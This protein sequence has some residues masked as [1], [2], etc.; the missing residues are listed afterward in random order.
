MPLP[1]RILEKAMRPLFAAT[2]FAVF[3]LGTSSVADPQKE[4]THVEPIVTASL[5]VHDDIPWL[6][7][8]VNGS[9]PLWFILDSGAG[10]CVVDLKQSQAL[11]LPTEGHAKGTGAG[12]GTYDVTFARDLVFCVGRLKTSVDRTQVIDLS[13]VSGPEG[14][15]LAGLLGYDF[16]ERRITVI[17]YAQE[18]LT[19]HDPKT[20]NV[21][22][23]GD[24]M[25]MVLKRRVPFV[26]GK[27]TVAGGAA[28]ERDWLVD[29]GSGDVFNDEALAGARQK[30]EVS[31][32]RGLGKEFQV[33]VATADSLELGHFSF[34][35]P[36]GSTGGM[37]IGGGLL[38]NFTVTFDYPSRRL[39]LQP[40]QNYRDGG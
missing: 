24:S 8:R 10:G 40:N 26:K 30:K 36:R 12:A 32:G 25:P 37:K 31:G 39:F 27:L 1:I 19:I 4:G 23:L 29:T 3:L 18:R 11:G 22:G 5:S 38:R 6:Q 16:F 35:Q 20:F 9:A 15:K 7:V 34:R 14:K 2:S 21:G 17:D 33:F 13:G 28:S